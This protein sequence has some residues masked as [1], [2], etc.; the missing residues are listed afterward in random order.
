MK[1]L[2]EDVYKNYHAKG[3]DVA[4]LHIKLYRAHVDASY[5][6]EYLEHAEG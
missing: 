4:K 5:D 1:T 2:R 6:V 3:M